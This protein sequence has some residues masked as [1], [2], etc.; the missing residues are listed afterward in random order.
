MHLIIMAYGRRFLLLV[1]LLFTWMGALGQAG[2]DGA[3]TITAA[4][5]VV[6]EY[7]TLTADAVA[8]STAIAVANAT[9]NVAGL[10][11]APLAAGDLIMIIQM[12]GATMTVPDDST[13][14]TITNLQSSGNYE[15]QQVASVN[16]STTMSLTCGLR[17]S[18]T[19]AGK[20]Q[21]IRVPRYTT[22]TINSGGVL[23]CPAWNGSTGGV[24]IVESDGAVIIN[25]GGSMDASGKGFR[26]GQLTENLA[27]YGVLNWVNTAGDFGG[28]K[29]EGVAGFQAE[30]DANG[31][32]FAKGAPANG[33]GG[34]NAHNAGGG[35]GANAGNIALWTGR[36]N[37]DNTNAT[38]AQAWNLEYTGFAA[39]TS[40]GGGKG[41][42]SFSSVN[43]NALTVGPFNTGWGGDY[44]R[45]NGGRGGRPL[46]YSTGKIFLGGGGGSG[47]QNDGRG[48]S[49][50]SGGGIVFLTTRGTVSGSGVLQANGADGN[51]STG[52]SSGNDGAGGAGAGGVVIVDADGAISGVTINANGGRGGNQNVGLVGIDAYGPGGGGGG[53]YIA[54]SNGAITRNANGGMNGVTSS[55]GMNEFPP[56]GATKGGSGLPN[57]NYPTFHFTV[58]G[59]TICAGASTSLSIQ[60]TG[61]VPVGTVFQWFNSATGTTVVGTGSNFNTPNLSVTTTYYVGTCASYYR[62]P[63]TVT[64]ISLTASFTAPSVCSGVS[65]TFSGQAS[66]S[67][68]TISSWTWSFGDGTPTAN[69][70]NVA[71]TYT[72]GGTYQVALSV[73][74]DFGC[75]AVAPVTVT[76]LSSPTVNFNSAITSGCPPFA[77]SFT[78]TT[79]SA[80]AYTWNFGDGFSSTASAPSHAYLL[81]GTYSVTLI[82]TNGSCADTLT[83][84]NFIV[85]NE[86]PVASFS[87]NSAVCLGDTVYF[88]NTSAIPTGSSGTYSWNFGDGTL[89]SSTSPSHVYAASGTYSVRLIT[90]ASGCTDDT[91]ITVSVNPAPVV[92]FSSSVISGCVPLT[93]VF[94]NTT[95]G[96]PTYSWNFGDTNNSTA[97]APT[98][99]YTSL[100]AYTVTLIATQG[101]CVD[102]LIRTSYITVSNA[103]TSAFSSL[104]S[105]CL[106]S[107]VSFT[108]LSTGNGSAISSYVWN[109]GD[110]SPTSTQ[111][112]PTHTF[113]STGTYAVT[114][115][116]NNAICSDDSVRTVYVGA[117]PTAVFTAS[118]DSVCGNTPVVFTNS[119]TQALSYQ[120]TFGDASS[121]ST[122]TAPSHTYSSN[123][124][125][126]VQFVAYNGGCS[127]TASTTIVVRP[128]P[129]AAFSTNNVCS[130]DSVRVTNSSQGNGSP[131]SS[132][133]WDFGDGSPVSST[134]QPSHYYATAGTYT[135][136]LTVGNGVCSDDTTLTV[137]VN[138]APVAGFS[139]VFTPGC[140]VT[141]ADFVNTTT[142]NP[143]YSWD[144]GDGT[145]LSTGSQPSHDYIST[146]NYTITLIANQG[147]CSDSAQQLYN[148]VVNPALQ[149]SF[150]AA[151]VCLG[152]TVRFTN[153]SSTGAATYLWDFGDGTSVSTST[154]PSHYYAAAGTYTVLL[155]VSNASCVVDTSLQI[156]VSPAPVAA[157]AASPVS[158]CAPLLVSFSNSTSGAPGYTWDFGDGSLSSSASAPS[159]TF[160]SPGSYQVLLTASQG[161]CLDTASL[162]IQ[163]TPGVQAQFSASN[164]CSGDS[165][166][167]INTSTPSAA[168]SWNF[169]DGSPSSTGYSVSHW[170]TNPGDY[171]VTL[172]VSGVGGCV[173]TVSDTVFVYPLPVATFSA[174]STTGCDSLTVN[175]TGNAGVGSIY[176][177]NF[178][179][180]G[181]SSVLSPSHTYSSAGTYS[182]TLTAT[183]A[184]GCSATRTQLNFIQVRTSPIPSFST[185]NQTICKNDCISFAGSSSG[186]PTSFIWGLTGAT[187]SSAFG[188]S[189]SGVCYRS[190][191]T[192]DVRL[193]VSDGFCSGTVVQPSYIQVVDC[194]AK[195]VAGFISSDTSI[196]DNG[197]L[198]FVSVSTNAVNWSWLFPGGTPSTSSLEQPT[199]ICYFTPGSYPVTLIASNPAGSDTIEVTNFVQ[200]ATLP[201]IPSFTQTGN[202]LYAPAGYAYQ[203]YY[204]NTPISGATGQSYVATL[205]GYYSLSITNTAGC[206]AISQL[207][208]VSL[209]GIDEYPE[210]QFLMYP[211]P[212]L[213]QLV[214]EFPNTFSHELR[215]SITDEIGR[216]IWEDRFRL[217]SASHVTIPCTGW[218]SGIYLF[219]V[220][221]E[222]GVESIRKLV[223]E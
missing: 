110:G 219:H 28:E 87:A 221:N 190:S 105:V 140:G 53:G 102:T 7:T 184:E 4:N 188:P 209:V 59:D 106:G 126:V 18:Y 200:V 143:T 26:G 149:A 12:Q 213:D 191:G 146:G 17:K 153:A 141:T 2:K 169:G 51:N 32:R 223:K 156:T 78:N 60:T 16:S 139:A 185:V 29:G 13:Y 31:G 65:A 22:L 137:S 14:G 148:V 163:V 158:G 20:T 3:K 177:W 122:M 127:D 217:G 117:V 5:T 72:S 80:T 68:G 79:L 71:H 38:Y 161:S 81:S 170:Y 208:Y 162:Q 43:L 182:V 167:F 58:Q 144:F 205:S 220:K 187:P 131:L 211:N 115:T 199:N 135:I 118:V 119:S 44:R 197:C 77:A 145:P 164:I 112:S 97:T 69:G 52:S 64:V 45:E 15:L 34:A 83:R 6:N 113:A 151:N 180:G 152:D 216:L 157:I 11:S 165:V 85:V 24:V 207:Q 88:T 210:M 96:S 63:V 55:N 36:G 193:T 173:S 111:T 222:E 23:T 178:G 203:W 33:G 212:V 179:D 49:G 66:T 198:T 46:D 189:I 154:G 84:T 194:S 62:V 166:R 134:L 99:T 74:N 21:V 93:V 147:T 10:F 86:N 150:S 196:C 67:L 171:P 214:I 89:S 35:G 121:A 142:G 1:G 98:H 186:S 181:S 159:H 56:N 39:S 174:S 30:Y 37:P 42:Y 168:Y 136:R 124:S 125:F 195:P 61:T 75:N 90:T 100:G 206:R 8:G 116:T 218:S 183:S 192:F 132:Y 215:L 202:T 109:F 104:D 103:P 40:T 120:W 9:L 54:V 133:A 123:G 48:G 114:L 107:P 92:A 82:A 155:Q 47:D 94:S 172:T 108:N 95:S 101:S 50:G 176:T 57:E 70:Q 204:N 76:I 91:T 130:G 41:G 73:N 25:A 128:Q 138:P 201:P 27:F 19:A 160:T 129:I 175:F